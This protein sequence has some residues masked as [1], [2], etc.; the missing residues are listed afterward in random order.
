[1]VKRFSPLVWNIVKKSFPGAPRD[2]LEDAFQDAW[3]H[4]FAAISKWSGG[5]PHAWIRRVVANRI[6]DCIRQ[7]KKRREK[8]T[9]DDDDLLP[10]WQASRQI[11]PARLAGIRECFENKLNA[12]DDEQRQA[13]YL[14]CDGASKED[15]C[16]Q[17]EIS[18]SQL[19]RWLQQIRSDFEACIK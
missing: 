6:K 5:L 3:L 13:F 11:D 16:K 10:H 18:L 9:T 14:L 17:L 19:N 2:V 7:Q 12:L 15:I 4:V 1:M 8:E